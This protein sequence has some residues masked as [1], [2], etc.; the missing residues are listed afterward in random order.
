MR[1]LKPKTSGKTPF[2]NPDPLTHWS[3]PENIAHVKIN[4][5]S[6]WALL[7]SGS[8]INSVSPEFIQICSLDIDPLSD[9]SDGT[10]GINGFGGVHT[11][12]LGYVII[13]VQ[14][15]GVRGYDEDQMA[16]VKTD[17]T[18]FGSQ[19]PVIQ[20]T[21]TNNRIIN[22]I[23]ESE[24]DELSASLNRSRIVQLLACC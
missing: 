11:Q 20:G 14:V 10:L 17:S 12:P 1:L 24:T 15:E 18:T 6:T 16:L 5:G 22:V 8:T 4:G 19:V 7:D 23:N 9:L 3:G 21:A 2:L 13:R